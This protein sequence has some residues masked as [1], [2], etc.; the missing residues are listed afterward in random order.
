MLEER[1]LE[2]EKGSIR[3]LMLSIKMNGIKLNNNG[4]TLLQF[5][6][7]EVLLGLIFSMLTSRLDCCLVDLLESTQMP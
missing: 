7:Y 4:S 2:K 1:T 6:V 3:M 5:L